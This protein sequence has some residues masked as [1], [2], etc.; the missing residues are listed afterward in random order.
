MTITEKILAKAAGIE[1]IHAGDIVQANIDVAMAHDGL[2]PIVF[3][4]IR[5]LGADLWDKDKIVVVIDHSAPPSALLHAQLA[6]ETVSFVMDYDIKHFFNMQGVAH[7]LLPERG[8]VAPGLIIVGTDS[9]T[10]TY[11]GLGAFSTGIGSTEMASVFVVGR[12]WFRVPETIK[13]VVGGKLG[14]YIMSKDVILKTLS[15][16]GA[17]GATYKALEFTGD[18][19][20]DMS[21][22]GRL[23]L[24]NMAVETGAKNGIIA[25]DD[26]TV[27]YLKGRY[28]KSVTLFSSDEDAHYSRIVEIDGNN[29][30]PQVACPHNP[31]NVV[32]VEKV[33]GKRLDQVL[34]GSCTNGRMEDFLAAAAFLK[35]RKIPRWLRCLI[36]PASNEI[37]T[38][39]MKE[40]LIDLFIESGCVILN[41]N[42]GPCGGMHE[43]LIAKGEI[44]LGTHNR[45][46]KG[47]MGSPEGEIYLSSPA[48]AG[49]SAVNGYITDPRKG[50]K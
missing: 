18:V 10:C 38:Q 15:L 49:A 2:G 33:E 21:V 13:V 50:I 20:R 40:G 41:A 29:L 12:L 28:E 43:G 39:L 26:K 47:R 6:H 17:A 27:E 24:C 14:D 1:S 46:F 23:T 36:L 45:N 42:C 7:Q 16:I 31:A 25:P 3:D 4:T 37:Y 44:V 8:F 35:G 34:I 5:N 11:G 19:I 22:D 48:T 32:P 30:G 9:H